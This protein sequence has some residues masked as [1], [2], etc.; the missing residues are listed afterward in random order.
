MIGRSWKPE[1]SKSWRSMEIFWKKTKIIWVVK[2]LLLEM[3]SCSSDRLYKQFHFENNFSL[4]IWMYIL[5]QFPMLMLRNRM[6]FI[7][8]PNVVGNAFGQGLAWGILLFHV[9][10]TWSTWCHSASNWA[11]LVG[12][13]EYLPATSVGVSGRLVLAR[14]L[15]FLV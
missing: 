7:V 15:F 8:S 14:S 13:R 12:T 2:F 9:V 11:C 5:S 3:P 4:G 10:L 6:S 1:V